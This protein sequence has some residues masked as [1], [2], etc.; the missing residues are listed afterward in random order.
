[1]RDAFV[2]FMAL[3]TAHFV[4]DYPLQGDWL[5]KAKNPYL[6]IIPGETIWPLAM[7]G[8]ALIHAAFVYGLTGSALLAAAETVAHML[9]DAAKCAGRIGYNTDQFAHLACKAFYVAAMVGG[10][11]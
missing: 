8:H 7:L 6:T 1:M 9:I 5:S 11:V 10:V 2:L 3:A 4:A